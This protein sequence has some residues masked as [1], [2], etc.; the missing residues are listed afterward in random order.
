MAQL[1]GLFV[2]CVLADD[3]AF[4]EQCPHVAVHRDFYSADSN[5]PGPRQERGYR[6]SDKAAHATGARDRR[7]RPAQ[8]N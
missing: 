8:V 7:T 4:A 6:D 5:C 2:A 1:V 3:P